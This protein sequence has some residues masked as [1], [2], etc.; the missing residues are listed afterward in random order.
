MH[1]GAV[2]VLKHQLI[3]V[4]DSTGRPVSEC[5]AELV[6]S[7][8]LS[9]DDDRGHVYGIEFVKLMDRIMMR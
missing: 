8:L 4:S 2:E 3:G 1:D 6:S 5:L 9:D 7:C